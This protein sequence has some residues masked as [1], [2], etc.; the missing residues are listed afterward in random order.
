MSPAF[1][2][3]LAPL[4]RGPL[5]AMNNVAFAPGFRLSTVDTFVL[6]GGTAA[7]IVLS[8]WVWW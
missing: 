1:V 3:V 5:D 2:S 7:A 4:A 8:M 6:V